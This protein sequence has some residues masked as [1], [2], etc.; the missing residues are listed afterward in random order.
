MLN[1]HQLQAPPIWPT[2]HHEVTHNSWNEKHPASGSPPK[3]PSPKANSITPCPQSYFT[4][5]T[6]T[7]PLQ[8]LQRIETSKKLSQCRWEHAGRGN[9]SGEEAQLHTLSYWH[10]QPFV[11]CRSSHRIICVSF[12]GAEAAHS[13]KHENLLSL[14]PWPNPGPHTSVDRREGI[15]TAFSL[16]L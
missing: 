16:T 14:K 13:E 5:R 3:A 4:S 10:L 1:S 2:F 6:L 9:A 7:P 11:V 8:W 12:P 15:C